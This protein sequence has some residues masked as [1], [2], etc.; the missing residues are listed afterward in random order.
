MKTA[1]KT[2]HTPGPWHVESVLGDDSYPVVW[3]P[4]NLLVADPIRSQEDYEADRETVDANA[5]LIAAAP[6]LLAA[7]D[8]L[9]QAA[10]I[11]LDKLHAGMAK[12]DIPTEL[13]RLYNARNDAYAAIAKATA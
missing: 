10:K 7:C 13:S 12:E 2:T 9:Q 5:R 11:V 4:D 1:T 6:E 8:N 3:G